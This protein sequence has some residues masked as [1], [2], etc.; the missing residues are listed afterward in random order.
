MSPPAG[1]P[2]KS[3]WRRNQR[4]ELWEPFSGAPV[5]DCL[6]D[7]CRGTQVTQCTLLRRPF[8]PSLLQEATEPGDSG[9]EQPLRRACLADQRR[10]WRSQQHSALVRGLSNAYGYCLFGQMLWLLTQQ[11]G[12][13]LHSSQ[14]HSLVPVAMFPAPVNE[15]CLVKAGHGSCSP[16]WQMIG[17]DWQ[18]T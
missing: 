7:C 5:Q 10:V 16:P 4:Q 18:A 12:P 3:P 14:N 8:C 2:M 13:F 6:Q 15:S 11:S 9:W 1:T 17:L